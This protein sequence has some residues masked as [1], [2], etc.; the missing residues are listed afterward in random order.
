MISPQRLLKLAVDIHIL[1]FYAIIICDLINRRLKPGRFHILGA[2]NP[3]KSRIFYCPHGRI[4]LCKFFGYIN[5]I[6]R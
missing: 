6:G 4:F 5:R 1:A 2:R 3:G